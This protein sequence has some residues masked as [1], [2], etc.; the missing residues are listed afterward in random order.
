QLSCIRVLTTR[1]VAPDHDRGQPIRSG[2]AGDAA[3]CKL[4]SRQWQGRA[5]FLDYPQPH[6]EGDLAERDNDLNARELGDLCFQ[7]FEATRDLFRPGCI[8]R[9]RASHRRHDIG[10]IKSEAIV[11]VTRSRDVRKAR[12]LERGHEEVARASDPVSGEDAPCAVR[13]MRGWSKAYEQQAS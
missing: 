12:L 5:S 1:V 3:V 9:R 4:R 2:Y 11:D 13:A 6:I 10:V 8:P 7:V